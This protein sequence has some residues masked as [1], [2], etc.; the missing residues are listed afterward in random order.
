M[1][2]DVEGSLLAQ[3]ILGELGP[4]QLMPP[5]ESMPDNAVQIII[6]WIE[7]GAQDN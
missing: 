3:M 7:N 6:E 5:S 2:E 1:P 4:D